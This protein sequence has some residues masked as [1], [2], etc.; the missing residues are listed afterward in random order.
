MLLDFYQHF[1]KRY[2][3]W[4][5]TEFSPVG[6]GAG[7]GGRLPVSLAGEWLTLSPSP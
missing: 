6:T 5:N 2:S 1:P 4:T 7:G 3:F